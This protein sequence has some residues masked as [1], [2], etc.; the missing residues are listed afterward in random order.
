MLGGTGSREWP[1][2]SSICLFSSQHCKI[3]SRTCVCWAS[4]L[5]LTYIFRL[6]LMT[7]WPGFYLLKQN[8]RTYDPARLME[9]CSIVGTSVL[10]PEDLGVHTSSTPPSHIAWAS[11]LPHFTL[12]P[13]R[14]WGV[15]FGLINVWFK[16]TFPKWCQPAGY[17]GFCL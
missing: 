12:S 11:W 6:F 14:R 17:W 2:I 1:F 7:F 16:R 5:P 8:W 15:H 13:E 3:E 4:T 10:D 9:T